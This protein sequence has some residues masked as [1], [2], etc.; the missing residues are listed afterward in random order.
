MKTV[1]FRRV[2]FPYVTSKR[3]CCQDD[4][5]LRLEQRGGFTGKDMVRADEEEWDPD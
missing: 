1:H 5:G 4:D 2:V 3:R